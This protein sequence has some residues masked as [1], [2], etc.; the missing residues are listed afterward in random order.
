MITCAKCGKVAEVVHY[1]WNYGNPETG[2]C[3]ADEA[4]VDSKKV[5]KRD[6]LTRPGIPSWAV[7]PF[8]RMKGSKKI[9]DGRDRVLP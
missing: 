2:Y 7:P 4:P 1:P 9:V 6:L 3:L 5:F 8:S